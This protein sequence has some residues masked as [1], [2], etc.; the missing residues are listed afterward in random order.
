MSLDKSCHVQLLADAAAAGGRK[1][2]LIDEAEAE[3]SSKNVGGPA[4][5]WLAF[6]PYY[7]EIVAKTG[8]SFLN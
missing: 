3:Y 8:G 7:D 4:K 2:I 6:Q 5:G 1:K